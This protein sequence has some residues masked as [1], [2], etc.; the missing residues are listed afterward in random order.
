MQG[1]DVA[2]VNDDWHLPTCQYSRGGIVGLLYPFY[3]V[4]FL[5]AAFRHRH[6]ADGLQRLSHRHF[7]AQGFPGTSSHSQP[8]F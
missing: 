6:A 1:L 5:A 4:R 8:D 3:F 2:A 7:S